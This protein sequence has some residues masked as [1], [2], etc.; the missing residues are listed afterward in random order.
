MNRYPRIG[1]CKIWLIVKYVFSSNIQLINWLLIPCVFKIETHAD[2]TLCAFMIDAQQSQ[3]YWP[4]CILVWNTVWYLH[5]YFCKWYLQ[6]ILI[7]FTHRQIKL[8]T[9]WYSFPWKLFQV[10]ISLKR[11]TKPTC[12]CD[13]SSV[14][15]WI[16]L[17]NS[18]LRHM[19]FTLY[20]DA[21]IK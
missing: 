12:I 19:N 15:F 9:G 13:H 10:W 6:R 17:V 11:F 3:L 4:T 14:A 2:I 21:E 8:G 1:T 5:I 18:W 7:V 20:G 16:S